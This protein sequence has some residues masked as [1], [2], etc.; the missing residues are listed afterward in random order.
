MED[1]SK[2]EA[3]IGTF[4]DISRD[5]L[6]PM[7]QKVQ[8]EKGFIPEEAIMR[9]SEYLNLPASKIYGLATF[10]NQFRFTPLGKYHICVCNGTGCHMEGSSGLL[11][12]LQKLL[13]IGEG[14]TSRDGLF[15]VEVLSCVGACSE[16]PV[17][18][19][20]GRYF[21]KVTPESLKE[22]IANISREEEKGK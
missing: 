10:Y 18:I 19:V 7:L 8:D 12:E 22:I 9:I 21:N 16:G 3:I 17:V 20:N 14:Q 6:I 4:P 15:S 13:K 11:K 5:V 2:I 1:N